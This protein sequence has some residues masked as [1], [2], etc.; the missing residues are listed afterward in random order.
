MKAFF[1][2]RFQ[3]FH[4]GHLHAIKKILEKHD[5]VVVGIG[6][7][8]KS[9][10]PYSYETRK[11]MIESVLHREG[12]LARCEIAEIPD[13]FDDKLWRESV[14]QRWPDIGVVVTGSQWVRRCFE[15]FVRLEDPDLL[16]PDMH[17][18]SK[19]RGLIEA[20]GEWKHFVPKE[21]AEIIESELHG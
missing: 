13:K 3:P 4:L 7:S 17:N 1:V 11:K 8:E 19:V 15:G 9:S 2:G 18:G 6:T 14:L 21:V 10:V 20:G 16:E 12:I 5:S